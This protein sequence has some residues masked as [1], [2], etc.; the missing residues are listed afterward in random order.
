M[1]SSALPPPTPDT[2]HSESWG[3]HLMGVHWATGAPS[4]YGLDGA[5]AECQAGGPALLTSR[6]TVGWGG[7]AGRAGAGAGCPPPYSGQ[8]LGG[9]YSGVLGL[10]PF[11]VWWGAAFIG[12]G[13]A[14]R[15]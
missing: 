2:Q 12:W 11:S 1:L 15:F 9:G 3:K 5:A 6:Q 13:G 14:L 4:S 7:G 10:A 8:A